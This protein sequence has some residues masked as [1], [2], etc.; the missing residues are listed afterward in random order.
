MVV[1]VEKDWALVAERHAH[2][3]RKLSTDFDCVVQ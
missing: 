2:I 1:I 3:Y